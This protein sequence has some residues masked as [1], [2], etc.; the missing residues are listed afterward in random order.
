MIAHPFATP[1]L[2]LASQSPRRA[3]LLTQLGVPHAVLLPADAAAAEAL[4]AVRV[5]ELPADYVQRVTQAKLDGALQQLARA[6]AGQP[7]LAIQGGIDPGEDLAQAPVLCADTTVALGDRILGKPTDDADA[8]HMLRALQGST[9]Q[10]LTAVT[11]AWRGQRAAA[12]SVSAV[13]FAPLNETD[14][15]RYV[16]SG[17]PRGKAGAYGIQGLAA[18]FVAHVAGSYTGIVGLPLFETAQLLKTVGWWR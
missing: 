12:L 5:G 15:A 18:Q 8:A 2:L 14:V 11:V 6:A 13:R 16:A 17:E 10:V 4:E 9:H 1:R 7:G 3:Q